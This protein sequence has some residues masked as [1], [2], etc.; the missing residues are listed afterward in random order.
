MEPAIIIFWVSFS[1]LFFCYIGYGGLLFLLNQVKKTFSKEKNQVSVA[2]WPAVTM[3]IAAYNEASILPGKLGNTLAIDYPAGHFRVIVVTDGSTDDSE[4]MIGEYKNVVSLHHPQRLGKLAAIGRAMEQVKTGI[5]VFSDANTM[6]N[7]ECLKR[8]VVHYADPKIGGVAGEKKIVSSSQGSAIGE[9]EGIYWK[10]ES[11]MKKQ[12]SDFHTVVGAAGELFS[13][14]TELFQPSS[15]QLLL[16][17]FIIS[18][19]VC[20]RGYKIKYEP[21]AFATE[22]PSAS[23]QEEAKRK[24]RISAGAYQSIGYLKECFNFFKHFWLSFQYVS[25]RLLRWIFCPWMLLILFFANVFIVLHGGSPTF[26]VWFLTLQSFFYIIAFVGWILISRVKSMGIITVPFY[27]LFM[28]YCL[29]RGF[30]RFLTNSQPV[31]WER[32]QRQEE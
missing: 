4:K 10:Y 24:I 31:L 13:I 2:E 12:D 25:R 21:G 27:F 1:I 18:M 19:Q 23:L 11:F 7:K 29:I 28:N 26:Y 17:D 22:F 8:I 3:I 15:S 32:S 9:A 16:D 6:L 14:R 20:L 30:I 5:V